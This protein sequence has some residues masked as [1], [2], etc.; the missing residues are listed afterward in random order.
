MTDLERRGGKG[1]RDE[2]NEKFLMTP[3]FWTEQMRRWHVVYEEER[4][5]GGAGLAT[6]RKCAK[7]KMP[8]RY[9]SGNFKEVA[10]NSVCGSHLSG[11]QCVMWL[12]LENLKVTAAFSWWQFDPFGK[13]HLLGVLAQHDFSMSGLFLMKGPACKGP[14]HKVYCDK[15][16]SRSSDKKCLTGRH[17]QKAEGMEVPKP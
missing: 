15:C 13:S 11:H 5:F 17:L 7:C 3:G 16:S 12:T 1:G 14:T 10:S 2:R 8:G 4:D 6:E 9:P